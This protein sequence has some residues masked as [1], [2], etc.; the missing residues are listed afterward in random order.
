LQYYVYSI[1]MNIC[2]QFEERRY[3]GISPTHKFRNISSLKKRNVCS[4]NRKLLKI[5]P[6][7]REKKQTRGRSDINNSS[8]E[9]EAHVSW[10]REKQQDEYL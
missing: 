7:K 1:T 4:Y 8:H 2:K 9:N 5:H 6:E 10:Q 3:A